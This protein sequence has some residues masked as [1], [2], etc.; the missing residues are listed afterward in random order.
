MVTKGH[1]EGQPAVIQTFTRGR[2]N[3]TNK[4][5][6]GMFAGRRFSV[7]AKFVLVPAVLLP[8]LAAT[9]WV[10]AHAQSRTEADANQLYSENVVDLHRAAQLEANVAAAGRIA[11]EIIPV[12][13]A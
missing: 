6:R 9:A 5:R 10:G 2:K 7:A 11:L 12:N 13:R 4:A 8:C 3:N 1:R